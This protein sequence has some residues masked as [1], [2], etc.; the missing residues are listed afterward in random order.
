MSTPGENL[1][2][3]MYPI[4]RAQKIQ[5]RQLNTHDHEKRIDLIFQAAF[6]CKKGYGPKILPQCNVFRA[7][8]SAKNAKY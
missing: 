6:L 7:I 4:T 8:F 5:E 1:S 2:E 3:R